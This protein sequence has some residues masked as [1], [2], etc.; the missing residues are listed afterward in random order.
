MENKAAMD[1]CPRIFGQALSSTFNQ[2]DGQDDKE[3]RYRGQE[4]R[5]D[6]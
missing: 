1:T 5:Q 4:N 2:K 6:T 3:K